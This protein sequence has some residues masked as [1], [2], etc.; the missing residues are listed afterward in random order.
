MR[1]RHLL[2]VPMQRGALHEMRNLE[3]DTGF[4]GRDLDICQKA[5]DGLVGKAGLAKDS[6]E[7]GIIAAIVIDLCRKGIRNP[8]SLMTMVEACRGVLAK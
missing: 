2:D 6:E 4:Y 5:F 7:A 8:E 1:S 3:K